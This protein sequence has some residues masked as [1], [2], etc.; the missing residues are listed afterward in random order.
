MKLHRFED[1]NLFYKKVKDYLLNDEVLNNLQLGICSNLIN[2]PEIYKIKPY[3]AAVEQDAKIIAVAMM[4]LAHELLLSKI[5]DLKAINIIAQDLHQQYES[6]TNV[7]APLIESKAFAEKMVLI[8][9][10]IL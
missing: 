1:A 4:T 2:N 3:L 8:N 9:K 7:N 6:L 5:T 10:F